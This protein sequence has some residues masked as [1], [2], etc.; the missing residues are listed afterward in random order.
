MRLVW[1][2]PVRQTPHMSLTLWVDRWQQQCCGQPWGVGSAVSWT[3]TDPDEDHLVPLFSHENGVV[4]DEAEEHHDPG[5]DGFPTVCGIVRSIRAVSVAY[6]LNPDARSMY[7]IP[8]SA[9][10][11][12][13][14]SSGSSPRDVPGFMGFIVELDVDAR[15]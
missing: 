9:T 4:I 10:L 2:G 5:V 3:V 6:E 7:P 1:D 8:G 12:S 13:V 14:S 15:H 11:T